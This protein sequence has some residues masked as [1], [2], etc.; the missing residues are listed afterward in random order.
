M[1]W[2]TD[3]QCRYDLTY[4]VDCLAD[5]PRLR[6]VLTEGGW[7][8]HRRARVL[9]AACNLETNQTQV[10]Q[11]RINTVTNIGIPEL[12]TILFLPELLRFFLQITVL[13]FFF[14]RHVKQLPYNG[15]LITNSIEN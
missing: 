7:L 13:R 9:E 8:C 3:Q 2:P 12:P 11:H 14:I 6:R 4:I 10:F 1:N 5:K 15:D